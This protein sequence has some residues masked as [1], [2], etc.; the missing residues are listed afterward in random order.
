MTRVV[1]S[2]LVGA[3]VAAVAVFLLRGLSRWMTYPA[4]PLALPPASAWRV[5]SA[6]V[7]VV[8]Y[9]AADGIRLR[10]AL[11][12]SGAADAPTAV[13]FHGNAEAAASNVP[14]AAALAERGVDVFLAEYRGYAGLSGRPTEAGLYADG[15]AAVEAVRARG[16]APER[17]VLVGRS[18]GT[19]VAVELALRRPPRLLVLV[20]P[21]TS[22]VDMGRSLVGPLA[23]LLVADRFD[24]LGKIGRVAAPVVVLHGTR[25]EVV[26]FAMGRR[27]AEA[28]KDG[29]LVEIPNATHNDVP[30][31]ESL[32]A[33][34][35]QRELRRT[36]G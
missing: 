18:L 24:S 15:E 17:L 5:G 8:D 21:Y 16:V 23:P 2:L 36:G 29:K 32:L 7:E 3:V 28:A 13:Y 12:R 33:S 34:E 26:P 27:I 4:S 31:L 9:D 22:I 11:V 1:Y 30:G 19:G 25:D 10:G 20:S 6:S 35:I 14:L